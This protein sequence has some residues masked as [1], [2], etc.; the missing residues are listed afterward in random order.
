VAQPGEALLDLAVLGQQPE[1]LL[2]TPVGVWAPDPTA[3][4]Q[5]RYFDGVV[6]TRH[7]SDRDVVSV[8]PLQVRWARSRGAHSSVSG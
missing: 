1:R 2:P 5:L 7:V 8:D 3:R 6:W 4:H